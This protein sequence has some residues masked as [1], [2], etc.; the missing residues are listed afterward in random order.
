M[1][2]VKAAKIWESMR[3]DVLIV[4]TTGSRDVTTPV[5]WMGVV[6]TTLTKAG[7]DEYVKAFSALLCVLLSVFKPIMG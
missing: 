7:R 3:A 6:N 1:F 4:L 5:G 2:L